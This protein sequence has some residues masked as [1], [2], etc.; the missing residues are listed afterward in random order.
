MNEKAIG[1]EGLSLKETAEIVGLHQATLSYWVNT[2]LIQPK[3][4]VGEGRGRRHQLSL[5][6][7]LEVMV[8]DRLRKRGLSMQR[9]RR[10]VEALESQIREDSFADLTLITDGYELF[11]VVKDDKELADVVRC[12]DGQGVF[13]VVLGDLWKQVAPHVSEIRLI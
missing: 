5:M 8:V 3:E 2:G 13:A 1:C 4:T 11:Q 12:H 10:A 6:N 7:L 9:L